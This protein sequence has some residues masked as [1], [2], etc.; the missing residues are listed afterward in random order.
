MRVLIYGS[1]EFAL[2]VTELVRHCGHEPVGMVDDFNDG[3]GIVGNLESV[4]STY[5][6]SE[7]GFAVAIGYLNLTAR[8][9]AWEKIKSLWYQT[10]MFV[11]PRAYVAD[12]AKI[13][14]GSLVMAGANVDVRAQIGEIAVIW[15]GVCVSHD[16]IVG[17]NSFLSPNATLCGYVELGA[18]C[19]VGAGSV[20]ADHCKV[21]SNTFI[22]MLSRYKGEVK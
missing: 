17:S 12:S 22:K 14:E 13:H 6:P 11:H 16:A 20:V 2:T 5:P 21:P 1:K 18:N 7:Y 15:P 9:S 4:A 8:W 3:P 10:P 19:F